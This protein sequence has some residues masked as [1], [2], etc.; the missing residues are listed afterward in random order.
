MIRTT[1]MT[2]DYRHFVG[3]VLAV[4]IVAAFGPTHAWAQSDR[5]FTK[6]GKS[7]SGAV[8]AV[9]K[10]GI[11]LKKGK[12]T[13]TI[14]ASNILKIQL[15]SEPQTLSEIRNFVLDKQYQSAID[16]LQ[17]LDVKTLKRPEM[18]AE[19]MFYSAYAKAQLAIAGRGSRDEAAAAVRNF[20]GKFQD[21]WH[22]Y[23]AAETLGDLAIVMNKPDDA[24]RFYGSLRAA[25][26]PDTKVRSVYLLGVA[27]LK[28]K[29]YPAAIA[30]F[31]KVIGL[32]ATTPGVV[33]MHTLSKSQKA[34][35]LA[36]TGKSDEALALIDTLIAELNPNEIDVAARVYN[37]QGAA[38]EASGDASKAIL[39]YL[40]THL[41]FSSAPDAHAEAMSRLTDLWTK[42]GKPDR[43]GEFRSLLKEL[44]PG[45]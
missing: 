12:E 10:Q 43:A 34:I 21:S 39:A 23:T 22:F 6:D 16:E 31:D 11:Q 9:S 44:Y 27:A 40:H 1:L 45:F 42:V 26:D 5:V 4:G 2:V 35:A 14:A 30:E 3:F 41:P 7:T 28:K 13:E 18:E 24:A 25:P 17:K 15:E 19:A 32:Q 33:R 29:D 38:Y 36:A 8:I 20:A 37:A